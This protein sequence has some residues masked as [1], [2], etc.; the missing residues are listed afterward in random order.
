MDKDQFTKVN[1]EAM[2]S[3]EVRFEPVGQPRPMMTM[4][5]HRLVNVPVV[6]FGCTGRSFVSHQPMWMAYP[7]VLCLN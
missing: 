6:Q 3:R 1:R 7:N 2:A 5:E 4:W